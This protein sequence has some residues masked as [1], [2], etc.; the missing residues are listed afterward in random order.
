MSN[1]LINKDFK[2]PLP[3]IL[4][5]SKEKLTIFTIGSILIMLI[6]VFFLPFSPL[7]INNI[8]SKEIGRAH[9]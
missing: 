9:V 1:F 4:M 8:G 3:V 2:K 7:N 6:L 5:E